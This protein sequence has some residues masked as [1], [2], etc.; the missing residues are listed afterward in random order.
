MLYVLYIIHVMRI[1]VGAA[2]RPL[3]RYRIETTVAFAVVE[4]ATNKK[5]SIASRAERMRVFLIEHNSVCLI[6]TSLRVV[7]VKCV[8]S[9]K[10]I[11]PMKYLAPYILSN[12]YGTKTGLL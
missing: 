8:Y 9:Y 4:Y 6:I 11:K 3:V 2:S 7:A 5:R 10:N 1:F 12:M